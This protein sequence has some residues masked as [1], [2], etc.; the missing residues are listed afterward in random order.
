MRH[1]VALRRACKWGL[2]WCGTTAGVGCQSAGSSDRRAAAVDPPMA[3]PM[4]IAAVPATAEP[5]APV[6]V[7]PSGSAAPGRVVTQ[8]EVLNWTARGVGS[9]VILDR[10]DGATCPARLTTADEVHLHAAGVSND[11]IRA[12]RQAAAN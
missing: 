3:T 7:A 6:A 2:L 11:V 9:D 4:R 5:I 1:S 10:L 12:L 8:D